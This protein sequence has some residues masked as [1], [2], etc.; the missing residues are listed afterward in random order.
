MNRANDSQLEGFAQFYSANTWNSRNSTSCAFAYYKEFLVTQKPNLPDEDFHYVTD[1]SENLYPDL[2]ARCSNG[3][4]LPPGDGGPNSYYSIL[5]PMFVDCLGLP[6]ATDPR[7]F[8]DYR[9]QAGCWPAGQPSDYS[10]E[11]DWMKFY[12]NLNRNPGATAAVA[13]TQLFNLYASLC[14]N[15]TVCGGST[16][17]TRPG[18]DELI[19]AVTAPASTF[20]AEQQAAFAQL[21]STYGVD[22]NTP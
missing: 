5:P 22:R 21:G 1:P 4:S 12:I 18:W 8:V 9:V 15:T 3:T 19:T 14:N 16:A 11:F 6:G 7:Q 13:I 10:T 2:G 17:N 20:S